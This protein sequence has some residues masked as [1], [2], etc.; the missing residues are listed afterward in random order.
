M[1]G[2]EL[3][4]DDLEKN[5]QQSPA[6]VQGNELISDDLEKDNQQSPTS[7]QDSELIS[8]DLEKNNQQS[9]AEI[10]GKR[11]FIGGP[12]MGLFR[13]I[14]LIYDGDTQIVI[15]AG[16]PFPV[17]TGATASVGGESIGGGSITFATTTATAYTVFFNRPVRGGERI[18]FRGNGEETTRTV[19]GESRPVNMAKTTINGVTTSSTTVS[20]TGEPNRSVT[21]TNSYG[22]TIATG[23]VG[24]D[25][26]YSLPIAK[27][28]VNVV[29]YAK[30]VKPGYGESTANTTVTAAGGGGVGSFQPLIIDAVTADSVTITGYGEP[31]FSLVFFGKG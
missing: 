28:L 10:P 15:A 4:S 16:R 11:E 21:V 8:D 6:S 7:V 2:S 14:D 1:Q 27:Q 9:P 20:G 24:S 23:T 22:T 17:G 26:K 13:S 3:T 30:V 19:R 18:T 12:A 5:N 31:N 29:V 25:G